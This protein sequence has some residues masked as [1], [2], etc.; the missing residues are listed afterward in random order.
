MFRSTTIAGCGLMGLMTLA[1]CTN[2]QMADNAPVVPTAAAT[3]ETTPDADEEPATENAGEF[4]T[5]D[6]GLKYRILEEGTGT[7]PTSAD[8]VKCH[9]RGWLDDGTE[10]DSSYQRGEPATFPLGGVIPG[11]TEGL[12]LVSEGGKIE[13]EIPSELGYGQRGAPPVIPPG[14]TLHFEVELLE[15]L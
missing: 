9:Y 13:L 6:S 10:F 4:K 15:V 2:S 12:Q 3:E 11:W 8:T 14:A 7:K 1:S 5:T